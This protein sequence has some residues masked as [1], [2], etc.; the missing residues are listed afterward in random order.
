MPRRKYNKFQKKAYNRKR[1]KYRNRQQLISIPTIKAI[2]KQVCQAQPEIKLKIV[3]NYDGVGTYNR[4][5]NGP[6]EVYSYHK[7][8]L[9]NTDIGEG[10]TQD[11]RIGKEIF[12]KGVKLNMVFRGP[13]ICNVD[14]TDTIGGMSQYIE[15]HVK[16]VRIVNKADSPITPPDIATQIKSNLHVNQRDINLVD[17]DYGTWPTTVY[18]KKYI[19]KAKVISALTANSVALDIQPLQPNVRVL[20]KYVPI[21]KKIRFLSNTD[22]DWKA[23]YFLWVYAY[24][25]NHSMEGGSEWGNDENYSPRM[26]SAYTVY[27][28]DS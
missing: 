22:D 4:I 9:N 15:L 5:I 14:M 21:N 1:K 27:Y 25:I 23:N 12:I 10:I 28:T 26:N 19:F 8:L 24:N 16:V 6:T 18:S 11:D 13:R 7:C 20:D 3:K 2:A 17:N